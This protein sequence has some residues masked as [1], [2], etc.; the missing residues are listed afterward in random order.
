MM[1]ATMAASF[2]LMPMSNL[3]LYAIKEVV[4]YHGGISEVKIFLSNQ[5]DGNTAESRPY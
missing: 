5:V 1:I 4:L 2:T 3:N